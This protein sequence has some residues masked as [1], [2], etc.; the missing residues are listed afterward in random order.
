MESGKA[1]SNASSSRTSRRWARGYPCQKL[2]GGARAAAT[3]RQDSRE[4][5]LKR[6]KA[7][8]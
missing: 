5:L 2:T 3:A 1:H 6:L 4:W 7:V 8:V